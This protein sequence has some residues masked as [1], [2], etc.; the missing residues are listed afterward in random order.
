MVHEWWLLRRPAPLTSLG[1][2]MRYALLGSLGVGGLP[3]FFFTLDTSVTDCVAPQGIDE[4]GCT[5]GGTS[6]CA[7]AGCMGDDCALSGEW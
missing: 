4:L 2:V 1:C 5:L 6:E 3:R 7:D